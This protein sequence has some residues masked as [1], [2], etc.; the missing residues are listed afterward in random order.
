MHRLVERALFDMAQARAELLRELARVGE[1]DWTRYVPYG[2]WT[3]KDLLAHLAA[4]DGVWAMTTQS[5]LASDGVAVSPGTPDPETARRRAIERGRKRSVASLLEELQSRRRLLIGYLELL[6]ERHLA[7]SVPGAHAGEDSVRAQ[8]WLGYHDR[9]HAADI[10]RA[11][12][13]AWQPEPR[14]FLPEVEAAAAAL[15]PDVALRVIY[16]VAPEMWTLSSPVPGWTYHDL[17]AHLA[18]GDRVFQRQLRALLAT[19]EAGRWPDEDA[20][21]RELVEERRSVTEE[22]L[23]EE[24]LSSRHETLRLLSQLRPGHLRATVRLRPDGPQRD[25]TFLDFVSLFTEHEARH[26]SALRTAVRWRHG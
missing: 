19:G 8:L 17:L 3:L 10:R 11:L 22:Q 26:L 14:S 1:A 16:S 20:D 25:R 6:E 24:Y 12:A 18:T 13:M 21:S 5:L 2:H 9:Q 15:S 4:F 23:I 7:R